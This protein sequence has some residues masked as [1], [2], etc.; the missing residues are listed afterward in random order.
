MARLYEPLTLRNAP[1]KF[2]SRESAELAKYTA[3][4]FL[5]MKVTFIRTR[6]SPRKRRRIFCR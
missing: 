4:A 2:V 5:A 1:I 3:N 6:Y